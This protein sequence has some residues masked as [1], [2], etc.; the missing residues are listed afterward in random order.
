MSF[1]ENPFAEEEEA[2]TVPSDYPL[3][4]YDAGKRE[5]DFNELLVRSKTL[6]GKMEKAETSGDL[7]SPTL[8]KPLEENQRL[9]SVL[10]DSWGKLAEGAKCH[11]RSVTSLKG[12]KTSEALQDALDGVYEQFRMESSRLRDAVARALPHL[13]SQEERLRS[14]ELQQQ[15]NIVQNN[16]QDRAEPLNHS[17]TSEEVPPINLDEL[18][19]AVAEL[20][21]GFGM[22]SPEE[23]A[24]LCASLEHA[25]YGLQ[26]WQQLRSHVEKLE[27]NIH[28]KNLELQEAVASAAALSRWTAQQKFRES[29]LTEEN[30]SHLS[31]PND[32]LMEMDS[33]NE[34]LRLEIRQIESA[35]AG[36]LRLDDGVLVPSDA[37][38]LQH[39]SVLAYQKWLRSDVEV[40][41]KEVLRLRKTL[42]ST[43]VREDA[44]LS[45]SSRV[46][47]PK[48]LP[49]DEW[50]K[51]RVRSD[52]LI[53]RI[54]RLTD[55][56]QQIQQTGDTIRPT[57]GRVSSAAA[58]AVNILL[59]RVV[60][61]QDGGLHSLA[62][63]SAKVE[64]QLCSADFLL[65]RLCQ[66]GEL[67]ICSVERALDVPSIYA[68]HIM[69]PLHEA[70]SAIDGHQLQVTVEKKVEEALSVT[71]E[72]ISMWGRVCDVLTELLQNSVPALHRVAPLDSTADSGSG[73][74]TTSSSTALSWEGTVTEELLA[75]AAEEDERCN[76]IVERWSKQEAELSKRL[77]WLR[78]QAHAAPLFQ[79]AQIE[80]ENQRLKE[81]L[82]A[83]PLT[84]S[85]DND[86]EQKLVVA[87]EELAVEEATAIA[88]QQELQD[89]QL[90]FDQL[91]AEHHLL[92]L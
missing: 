17:P 22:K 25:L 41:G 1:L 4:D 34:D 72:K 35:L 5:D 63:L 66:D 75:F 77:S 61:L 13:Q 82:G 71:S 20:Q 76:R 31:Q 39:C 88:L 3:E 78:R 50:S 62:L 59:A 15:A 86:M 6:E 92:E 84:S 24:L 7:G 36:A 37:A 12:S 73:V 8:G 40:L 44:G 65:R 26:Y 18:R 54:R 9:R 85:E 33:S 28:N 47:E 51:H 68:S 10:E 60:E 46:A 2:V 57:I 91:K 23:S 70:V 49:H 90:R 81:Q 32:D 69:A 56:T 55:L 87:S 45:F 64:K 38:L 42:S 74:M 11:H 53:N 19:V 79:L 14:I 89:L 58:D 29:L 48:A 27:K 83:T 67:D 43:A 52:D 16:G 21:R 80:E 30:A